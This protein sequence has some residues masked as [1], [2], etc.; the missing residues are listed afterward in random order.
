MPD[1]IA[2]RIY[3]VLCRTP[4]GPIAAMWPIEFDTSAFYTI[5]FGIELHS[6]YRD[7]WHS[8]AN[9]AQLS[10]YAHRQIALCARNKWMCTSIWNMRAT[11]WRAER[12]SWSICCM[13][14]FN[15]VWSGKQLSFIEIKY[16][17]WGTLSCRCQPF[18]CNIVRFMHSKSRWFLWLR[19]LLAHGEMQTTTVFDYENRGKKIWI[20]R[21]TMGNITGKPLRSVQ[22][23]CSLFASQSRKFVQFN[24]QTTILPDHKAKKLWWIPCGFSASIWVGNGERVPQTHAYG[25]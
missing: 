20:K 21:N 10:K 24:G 17:S 11:L 12:K 4:S 15:V 16:R 14:W 6:R 18:S 13:H 8:V 22:A 23:I 3:P 19:R 7:G 5:R 1:P 2:D 25:T 9:A